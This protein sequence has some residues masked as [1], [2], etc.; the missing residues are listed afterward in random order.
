[1]AHD[2]AHR[3]ATAAIFGLLLVAIDTVVDVTMRYVFAN[4]IRGYIDVVV[5][6]CAVLL[7]ACMPY[8][9][10]MRGDIAIDFLGKRIGPRA[11][12]RLNQFGALATALFFALMGWQYVRYA[13]ELFG[14]GEVTAVLRWPVWPWWSAVALFISL[15]ALVGFATLGEKP[16]PEA[17]AGAAPAPEP[18]PEPH[19]AA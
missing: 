18:E 5:L 6:A 4:P 17:N 14:N 11:E 2:V 16:R 9:V 15:A 1:M 8:V 19:P 13:I 3:L 10:V 12:T 7:S